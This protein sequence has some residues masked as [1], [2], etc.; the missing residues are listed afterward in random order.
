[1]K[2][3]E[4]LFYCPSGNCCI[5]PRSAGRGTVLSENFRE[6]SIEVE[7]DWTSSTDDSAAEIN[8]LYPTVVLGTTV[9]FSRNFSLNFEATLEPVEDATKDRAFEDY[10]LSRWGDISTDAR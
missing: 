6:L 2:K 3:N 7:N 9:E 10:A 8:D 5:L 1:M 4:I